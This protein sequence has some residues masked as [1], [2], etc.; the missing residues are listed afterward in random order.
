MKDSRPAIHTLFLVLVLVFAASSLKAQPAAR[1]ALVEQVTSASC[2]PC[3]AQNPA[4]KSLLE[5]NL[6]HVAIIK[7]QR[8]GGGY[9]DPMWSF[10]PTQVD[11]RITSFY[12]TFSFPQ[13]WINGTYYGTPGS[14]SQAT[15]NSELSEP[16]WWDIAIDQQLSE[17]GDELSV[18]VDFT[19]LRDFQESSDL[20]LRAYVV[21][22]EDEVNYP[23]PPGYNNERDFYWVMRYMLGGSNGALLGQQISGEQSTFEYTYNIDQSVINPERLR[24]VAFVQGL[25]TKEVHQAALYREETPSGIP[26]LSSLSELSVQPSLTSNLLNLSFSLLQPESLQ[27]AVYDINGRLV[28]TLGSEQYSAGA[29]SR[30]FVLADYASGVYFAALRSDR[31]SRIARFT[32]VR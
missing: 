26:V 2:N 3:A 8:G 15:I 22:I 19:A 7:Y 11:S 10:N 1:I 14:I 5:N 24:V 21:I 17:S 16:A 4:F 20:H 32:V 6:D 25:T 29:H 18:K 23:S 27:I 12:G 13:A 30:S 28:E 9:L 31:D